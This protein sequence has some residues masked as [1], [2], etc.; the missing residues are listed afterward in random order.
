MVFTFQVGFSLIGLVVMS[1]DALL[2]MFLSLVI[3]CLTL[4]HSKENHA[5]A[6]QSP[7]AVDRY[8]WVYPHPD[9]EPIGCKIMIYS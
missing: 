7:V 5:Q 3:S 9:L 6:M 8:F 4:N 2:S 1:V